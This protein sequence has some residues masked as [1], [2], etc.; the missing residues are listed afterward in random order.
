MAASFYR[1]SKRVSNARIKAELGVRLR[2][3]GYREGLRA[4]LEAGEGVPA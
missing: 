3:P 4:L 1:D 2:Y